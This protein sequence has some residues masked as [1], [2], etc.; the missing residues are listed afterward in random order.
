MLSERDTFYSKDGR[1]AEFPRENL[2]NKNT[3]H[4]NYFEPDFISFAAKIGAKFD[5]EFDA[6]DITRG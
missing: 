3:A 1:E 2:L 4:T 6:N 5:V